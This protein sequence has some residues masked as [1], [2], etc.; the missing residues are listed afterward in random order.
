M[1]VDLCMTH[2]STHSHIFIAGKINCP[3]HTQLAGSIRQ[4]IYRNIYLTA[5]SRNSNRLPISCSRKNVLSLNRRRMPWLLPTIG[6][7]YWL[8]WHARG[9]THTA[10]KSWA[11]SSSRSSA[12]DRQSDPAC[13]PSSAMTHT[14]C[15]WPA[16]TLW[17]EHTILKA[18]YMYGTESNHARLAW[19]L[20]S[21]TFQK[22][23]RKAKKAKNYRPEQ[24]YLPP[25]G[26]LERG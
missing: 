5:R 10:G 21:E 16:P 23:W 26:L 11:S 6:T 13:S 22:L 14:S 7:F 17:E 25:P 1:I 19:S 4:V 8:I 2:Q 9:Y 20:V 18:P 15:T 24:A 3:P 12:D